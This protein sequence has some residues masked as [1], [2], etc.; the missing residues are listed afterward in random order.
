MSKAQYGYSSKN[1]LLECRLF[2][3]LSLFNI[4]NL[5]PG[6]TEFRLAHFNPYSY[7]DYVR[8]EDDMRDCHILAGD[9]EITQLTTN[10]PYSG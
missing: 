7:P 2:N 10:S 8:T 4:R 5:Y 1:V 3:T 6:A 9:L